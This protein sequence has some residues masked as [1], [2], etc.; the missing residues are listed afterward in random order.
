MPEGVFHDMY[1]FGKRVHDFANYYTSMEY[2][3]NSLSTSVSKTT[4]WQK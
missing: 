2:L 1:R 3:L 4:V